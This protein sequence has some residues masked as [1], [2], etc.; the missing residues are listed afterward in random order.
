MN[1]WT[2]LVLGTCVIYTTGQPVN[3][4]DKVPVLKEAPAEVLFR[5]GQA[6]RLE[7]AT[8]GD[9]SGV[10]YSW[11]KDGMHF[12]V[13]QDTLTTIDA[14]S[15]VFS[16]TK[17]SDEGEYQC[18]AK[19]DFGVAS[20][21]ATKLRRTY[22]ETPAFE[23]KKVT[24]VEG[25]PF[26]LRCPVPGGYP[27]PTISWM[28]H[29]DEDGSTETFMDRRATYSPEGTLYF[30]NAS[31]DDANDKTKLVCMASS[32]AADEGVPIVAYY[33]TQVTPASEPTYGEL[34][35]QYL[36]DH[37][38]AKVGDL[39]YLYC[40]YGGT[41]L[42][43]PSWSKDGVNVDNTY[44][45][46]ITRHNRSSGRRLV[47]K[48]VWAEDA[49]T[50]TCDVDNQAGRRLQHTITFSVVS[51][52]TFT[53]KPEKRTLATQGEDVTIPCKATGIPS[54]L[55]SWTYNGEPVTEGVTGDGLVI[56]AVNKSNQGY[57]GCT[58]SNEHGAEYAETALQ[59]A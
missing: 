54:P 32:P 14:G 55:V 17:A 31:L 6:T 56:K 46:R 1:S 7:C 2:L 37:V 28:R 25:K 22:I 41:P 5:E 4:G 30:S 12:S 9:D 50:Y 13:G 39:T 59:V 49:G 15:L 21:R 42:A 48:E 52:P 38:V 35:P 58:A 16:Q 10:E 51:A 3:S 20:T 11:R 19:S 44:K 36:S 33:I 24:V 47:I 53:T 43:H 34:I 27:K 57:Y 18:F 40:I 26:E 29:H 23:E 45:D 8:E